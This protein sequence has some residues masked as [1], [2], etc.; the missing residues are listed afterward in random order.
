M[1]SVRKFNEHKLNKFAFAVRLQVQ[2]H[3]FQI[4][5]IH[6]TMAMIFSLTVPHV[7]APLVLVISFTKM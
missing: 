2:V 6:D 7:S 3:V 4:R 5:D 1:L